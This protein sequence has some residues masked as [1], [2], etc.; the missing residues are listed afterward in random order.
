M[1]TLLHMESLEQHWQLIVRMH[2]CCISSSPVAAEL[3]GWVCAAFLYRLRLASPVFV[4]SLGTPSS[5]SIAA[6]CPPR[7]C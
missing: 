5:N 6:E 2:C 1:Q 7:C 3:L 4:Q